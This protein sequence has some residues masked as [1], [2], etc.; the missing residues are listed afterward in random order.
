[1]KKGFWK[2]LTG[3][4]LL[5]VILVTGMITPGTLQKMQAET[6]SSVT[7]HYKG[8]YTAPNIYYWNLNGENNMPVTWPGVQM[9]SESDNWFGYTFSNTQSVNLIINQNGSQ[10]ANLYRT[11]GEWWYKN[12]QWYQYNPDSTSE[13]VTVH[14]KSPW[15]GAKIYYWNIQ[16][17]GNTITWPGTD[18][19]PEG[20]GWYKYTFSNASLVHLIFNYNG[21][22]TAD[23]SRTAGEWWYKDNQWYEKNPEATV[24][25]T[26]TNTPTPTVTPTITP[27]ITPTPTVTP[28]ITP[29]ITPTPEKGIDFRDETIYFVM[30]TRFYDGDSSNNV[31]CWDEVAAMKNSNDAAWRGDFKGLIEKLDYIKAL[32]F[33]AIWITPVVKNMSGYDYHGYHAVNFNEIDPR[34]ESD[35]VTYQDLINAAHE[36]GLKIIQ[37]MVLNHTGNFGEENLYPLFTKDETQ[38]DTADAIIRIDEGKLPANYETLTPAQ[39][40]QARINAM[41]EDSLDTENI[42]HHEKSLSWEGYTVQTGQIAGDCV[43]LNT[44]NPAVSD[45]LI[46][47]YN[48]YITMGVDA[49]RVD[50]VKHISR[51]TFNKDFIPAF[52]A[53]GGEDF[54]VFGEVATRYRQVWN[55]NIPAISTPFYTWAE[56]SAYPWGDTVTNMN[57]VFQHWNDNQNVSTQPVSRNHLLNGNTYH[58][59]DKSISSGLGVIDFPMHWNFNNARDAFRVGVDGDQYYSD[60][61][62]NV[63]YVDSHDYAPDG[64]PENQRF[65]GSQDTWAENLNLMYTFRGIPSIYYGSEIEFM[66]GA[67]I[68]AGPTKPLS[69]TGRAY[70]GD[71][72]EGSVT[73]TDY[74]E[75]TN[76]TGTMAATLNHPLSLHIQRLNKI[77]RNIPA[78]RKGQY[79]TEGV[80]GEMA[81]KRRYTDTS[82]GV[83]SFVLVSITD[84]AAF[85]G[86]PNGTYKDAITGDVKVITDGKLTIPRSGKGN[87]RI[88]VLDLP[89]NPAPGKVGNSGTYL[90]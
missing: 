45:Y 51:L 1:M 7:V 79:S 58:T 22:Q 63:T 33:S 30:I 12:N 75:Y 38:E 47:A 19:A 67:V 64:A 84:G 43:D 44:E 88:Y 71:N 26:P 54:F 78:L 34:Y 70:F 25:P 61:T 60:A 55:S 72:I 29:T 11:S 17:S 40:Y 14:F 42:Y 73:V 36:K 28:T 4:V 37:D 2:K 13:S 76:A 35:G 50:T 46:N 15:D 16:P 86:I 10:T 18:M 57:S 41:K 3:Y 49:F 32:G 85:S 5:I 66:K 9:K 89:G 56:T 65:A 87:M 48:R 90:K 27:T 53:A 6:V 8:T 24:T 31:H 59:P 77:R 23:L 20:N 21:K 62:W 80:S 82:T 69:E 68:D 83:D 81:F 74:G 39:Q 52:K